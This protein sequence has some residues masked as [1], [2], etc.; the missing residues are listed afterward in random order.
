MSL[1]DLDLIDKPISTK[2]YHI[3]N[4]NALPKIILGFKVKHKFDE[5]RVKIKPKYK[6]RYISH[7]SWTRQLEPTFL[8]GIEIYPRKQFQLLLEQINNSTRTFTSVTRDQY[9]NEYKQLLLNYKISCDT[10]YSYL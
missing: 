4:I 10:C 3:Y 1:H 9:I 2:D 5:H 6:P 7:F 8:Y